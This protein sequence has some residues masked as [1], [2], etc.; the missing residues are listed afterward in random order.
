MAIC[1]SKFW[2]GKKVLITGHTGFKGSWLTLLLQ[3][4]GARVYGYSID[5]PTEPSLFKLASISDLLSEQQFA[6]IN[7]FESIDR[8]AQTV[9]PDIVL[10]LAAQPLVRKS[11]KNPIETFATN[12][13]GTVN[14]IES[15]RRIESVKAAVIITTDKVYKNQEWNWGYREID[16]LGGDDPYSASKAAAELVTHA[17]RKSFC[18]GPN[19]AAIATARAGN[20]IGGGDWGLER[21]IPDMV[22]AISEEK[23]LEIRNPNAVRP[24]QHVLDPL[25]GYLKLAER[26]FNHSNIDRTYNFGPNQDSSRPVISLL[27]TFMVCMSSSRHNLQYELMG[28]HR[29]PHETTNLF[30]DSA[31]ARQDLGWSSCYNFEESIALT[32]EWLQVY[33]EKGD[34]RKMTEKQV[35]NFINR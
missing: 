25:S 2:T 11:Y 1:D 12:I 30:L 23:V 22:R 16:S 33:L 7:N 21:I 24:W 19:S 35:E 27:K 34:L 14:L 17:L 10:H 28:N 31:K 3:K 15:I 32:W 9:E 18:S 8:F 4:L 20:V 13:M 5:I 6:D 26:L 29:Q